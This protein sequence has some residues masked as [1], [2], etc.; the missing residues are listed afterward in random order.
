MRVLFTATGARPHLYPLVPL[1]WAFRAAGHDV[2]LASTRSVA[3]D[4]RDTGL[5]AV[6]VHSEPGRDTA[7]RNSF[8][9]TIHQ[10]DPWPDEWAVNLHRLSDA[11][12]RYLRRLGSVLVL[13]SETMVDDLVAF[14]R[15]WRPGLVV[16]DAV[17]YAGPVAAE[18]LGVPSVR[19]NFGT[20]SVPRLEL[21]GTTPLPEYTRMFARYGVRVR[22]EPTA[23]V[24]PTPPRMRLSA[25]GSPCFDVRYVAYNGPGA[26]PARLRVRDGRPRICVTWGHTSARALGDAAAEPYRMA[27]D[28]MS[29]LDVEIVV[30]TTRSQASSLDRLP[31]CAWTAAA[32]PL[33]LVLPYCDLL[34]HQGGDGTALTAATLGVP[35]LAITRKPDAELVGARLAAVGIGKHL[36]YQELRTDPEPEV[37]IRRAVRGLLTGKSWRAAAGWLR[38]EIERLPTPAAIEPELS[39]LA[40]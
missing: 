2:C 3:A 15:Q 18:V 22:L 6:V 7:A 35:Q 40:G 9:E 27:I 8:V 1:A 21:T 34:V 11:Q 25:P 12:R 19:H 10:Q 29:S 37:V 33:Q 32:T 28:A 13:G 31:R 5:P 39:A 16:H 26:L 20:A 4:L 38:A 24:D 30:V 23:T 14:A 17:S 36:R